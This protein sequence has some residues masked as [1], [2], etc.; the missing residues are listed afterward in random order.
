MRIVDCQWEKDNIGC[1][2]FEVEIEK[3]DI[4]SSDFLQDV[5]SCDYLVVK[6]PVGL[7]AFNWYLGKQRFTCAETQIKYSKHINDFDFDDRFIRKMLPRVTYRVVDRLAEAGEILERITPDMFRTDRISMDPSFG[8]QMG[9][10]RYCNYLRNS[11]R[12]GQNEV[13]GVYF[14]NHLVGFEMFAMDGEVCHGKLGG[15]YPDVKI[16]G[17]GFL[18]ACSPLL[19]TSDRYG[20][21][22]F[23]ADVSSNNLAVV[24]LYEYMHSHIESMTYV[25]A[26]HFE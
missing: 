18:V 7:T 14:D 26:K 5:P 15:I 9:C 12:S 16:P 6:V 10:Q 22:R 13:I 3:N 17:L 19:F 4:F 11:I 20:A 21:R 8:P 24:S 25:F 2:V 1:T 23:L